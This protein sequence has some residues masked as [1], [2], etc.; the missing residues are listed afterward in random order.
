MSLFM[1]RDLLRKLNCTLFDLYAVRELPQLLAGITDGSLVV[2]RSKDKQTLF[3]AV[4]D[5]KK[6]RLSKD[7]AHSFYVQQ[8]IQQ[9]DLLNEE[10]RQREERQLQSTVS[11]ELCLGQKYPELQLQV[12]LQEGKVHY[13]QDKGAGWQEVDKTYALEA[14]AVYNLVKE[15]RDTKIL[16][17]LDLACQLARKYLPQSIALSLVAEFNQH[18]HTAPIE[19]FY[20]FEGARDFKEDSQLERELRERILP[21]DE[22]DEFAILLPAPGLVPEV[23]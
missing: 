6:V 20:T 23:A 10:A 9:T 2:T 18:Y 5:R 4:H 21:D 14:V 12:Q 13:F 3:Y 8:R 19:E 16:P 7:A 22:E 17:D 1:K 11:E 15:L